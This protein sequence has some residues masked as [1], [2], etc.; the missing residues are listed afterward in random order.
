MRASAAYRIDVAQALLRKALIEISGT[1]ASQTR[2]VGQR[3]EAA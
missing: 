2:V 1:P 3:G